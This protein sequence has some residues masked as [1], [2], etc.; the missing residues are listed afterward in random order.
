LLGIQSQKKGER[1]S[2]LYFVKG[3]KEIHRGKKKRLGPLCMNVTEFWFTRN[4]TN[5][6]KKKGKEKGIKLNLLNR[7]GRVA[8]KE[9]EKR[10]E[11]GKLSSDHARHPTKWGCAGEKKKHSPGGEACTLRA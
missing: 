1:K 11:T 8:L 4:G 5:V 9:R 3:S 7:P 2:I 6:K 10:G